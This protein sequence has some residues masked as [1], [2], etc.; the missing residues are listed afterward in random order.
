MVPRVNEETWR[1]E[2]STVTGR[3]R[4]RRRRRRW[5]E[6]ARGGWGSSRELCG[7]V[8][9]LLVR[10]IRWRWASAFELLESGI[11]AGVVEML[12]HRWNW[13]GRRSEMEWRGFK[14]REEELH[15]VALGRVGTQRVV[16]WGG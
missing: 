13:D 6:T 8:K 5:S 10:G 11:N 12:L 3:C 14:W 4:R 7:C 1:S 9:K 16:E 15:M 2:L